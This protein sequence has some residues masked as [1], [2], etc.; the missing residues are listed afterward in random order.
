[1][2]FMD[3][4]YFSIVQGVGEFLPISS[5]GHL[6]LLKRLL[7]LEEMPI[8]FDILLHVATLLAVFIFFRTQILSLLKTFWDSLK[9]GFKALPTEEE[10]ENQNYILFVIVVTIFT[11]I[12]GITIDKTLYIWENL[13]WVS[14]FFLV[15]AFLLV[16]SQYLNSKENSRSNI[17]LGNWLFLAVIVGIAQGI[18][19]IPGISRSGI[20]IAT[21]LMLR[22]PRNRVAEISFIISIP[23]ILGAIALHFKDLKESNLW[24]LVTPL[25]LVLGMTLTFVIGYI[26]L[27]IL[28]KMLNRAKLGYFS[29]YLVMVAFLGYYLYFF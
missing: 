2:S 8:I 17:F 21:L 6:F 5:S 14:T 20:T 26:S 16:F 22:F 7:H 12:I 25:K 4:I 29:I 11:G 24:D 23:A 10:R 18:G 9:N 1:M 3:M 13:F 28:Q 15:T 19:T 27:V